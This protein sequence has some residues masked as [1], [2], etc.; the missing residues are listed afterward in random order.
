MGL[1]SADC[2]HPKA[3]VPHLGF[4]PKSEDLSALRLPKNIRTHLLDNLSS[5]SVYKTIFKTGYITPLNQFSSGQLT[6]SS[7]FFLQ[8]KH[9]YFMNDTT[10]LRN[11]NHPVKKKNESKAG[12]LT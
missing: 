9:Q 5:K 8:S 10:W 6:S 12:E 11:E 4:K 1:N 2:L 7:L 3:V